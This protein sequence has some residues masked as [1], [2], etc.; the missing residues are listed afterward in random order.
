M[1]TAQVNEQSTLLKTSCSGV[2]LGPHPAMSLYQE[3]KGLSGLPP[4]CHIP[5]P[6]GHPTDGKYSVIKHSPPEEALK[7]EEK[8]SPFQL[9]LTKWWSGRR[10]RHSGC[11]EHL[12]NVGTHVTSGKVGKSRMTEG[13]RTVGLKPPHPGYFGVKCSSNSRTATVRNIP[14]STMCD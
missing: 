9:Q 2:Q 4:G 6:S 1:L 5:M 8:N 10:D 3:P 12:N 13:E 7:R 14:E 11:V